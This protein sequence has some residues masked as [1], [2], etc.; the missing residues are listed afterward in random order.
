MSRDPGRLPG[1]P[2]RA[3]DPLVGLG[4]RRPA[5]QPAAVAPGRARRPRFAREARPPL[6]AVLPRAARTRA[7]PRR[8]RVRG[9]EL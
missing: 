2:R 4:A 8:A 6:D 9:A 5:R 3:R 7:G 1:S